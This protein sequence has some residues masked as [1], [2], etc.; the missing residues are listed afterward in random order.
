MI[1]RSTRRALTAGVSLLA[2]APS[3]SLFAQ[4]ALPDVVVTATRVE[5]PISRAGGAISVIRAAD[6]EKSGAKGVVD[7]LRQ[8]P[9]LDVYQSGGV[10]G[11]SH[12]TLRGSAAGQTLVL[13]DGVRVGDPSA[14]GGEFDFGQFSIVDI[15]R[16]EVL[17]G[18]QSALYGSDAMGGVVNVITRKGVGKPKASLTL[19][20]GA[21]G[22]LHGRAA[23]S[24]G[25]ETLS[26]AFGIDGFRT[27]G[28]SRYGYRIKRVRDARAA[29]GLPT[30]LERDGADKGA[31]SGRVT[32]R[33][34]EN[35]RFEIGG[36]GFALFDK[37]DNPAAWMSDPDD[38]FMQARNRTASGYARAVVDTLGGALTHTITLDG[39]R[40]DRS[41]RLT[42]GCSDAFWNSYDC[43]TFFRGERMGLE[44]QGALK[45]GAYGTSVFGL[46]AEREW[47]RTQE[48]WFLPT[49]PMTTAPKTTGLDRGQTTQSAFLQH[50]ILFGDRLDLTLGGR[51][52]RVVG[53]KTFVTG[54]ATLAYLLK[55]TDTKLRASLGTGAKAA[56]L[57]QR[58]SIY[59]DPNLRPEKTV[60]LDVGLDQ[61][62]LD[63]RFK[64]SATYFQSRY[65]D[66]IDFNF[67][68]SKY[69]NVARARMSGVELEGVAVVAPGVLRLRGNYTYLHAVDLA[70]RQRLLRRPLNKGFLA[71]TYIGVPDLEL[72]ARLTMTGARFDIDNQT[73]ARVRTP[74][75]ARLDV[76][77]DYRV[78]D[79]LS[80]FARVENVT[81]ARYEEIRDYGTSGRA[82]YAGLKATW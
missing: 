77:A 54:R 65:S 74:A 32:W 55:E 19:E 51:V 5:E 45:L 28:F 34:S 7:V 72:E 29:A 23:F 38:R 6:I 8:V 20:G 59:G 42:L 21:Y 40:T 43:R 41:N 30:A 60:G 44:Y 17:R 66:L 10:G 25:T 1:T 15:E 14:T 16:I 70:T 48:Q 33:L 3:S 12:A 73:F 26:W 81:N 22:T 18:P 52:D 4:D 71:A 68:T 57:F 31:L 58:Y 37:L 56:T 2:F 69:F 67:Q 46:K 11:L 50:Q 9:G 80:L 78:N 63:G 36:S 61:T 75:W 82:A 79:T 76:S 24:G 35:V 39:S 62:F 49:A 47:A 27:D 53:G 64:L 13:I